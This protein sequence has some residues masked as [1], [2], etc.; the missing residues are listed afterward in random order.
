MEIPVYEGKERV[1]SLSLREEGLY[2][3]FS[4]RVAF[5]PGIRRLWLC[6]E[7]GQVCLG[8]LQP[9]GK[10]LQLRRRYSRAACRAFPQS[11]L[12]ASLRAPCSPPPK[13]DAPTPDV[14]AV[15][16]ETGTAQSIR[17]FGARFIVFRS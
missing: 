10:T 1:G 12:F 13:Q 14:T 11:G 3:V 16:A 8:V 2:R 5:R 7:E 17:L 15:P 4:A 9:A 6:G